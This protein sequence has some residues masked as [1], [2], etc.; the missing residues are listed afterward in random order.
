MSKVIATTSFVA[1][2]C[3]LL[4]LTKKKKKNCNQLEGR[5][6]IWPMKGHGHWYLLMVCMAWSVKSKQL[7]LSSQGSKPL[8]YF[9]NKNKK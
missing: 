6:H 1:K 5:V 3:L 7:N 8:S 2:F 9:K 4:I